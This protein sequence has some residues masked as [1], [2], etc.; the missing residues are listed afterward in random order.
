MALKAVTLPDDL[1]KYLLRA[2]RGEAEIR[3]RDLTRAAN[4]VARSVRSLVFAALAIAGGYG[5][6]QLYL[7]GHVELARTVGV[8]AGALLA[9]LLLTMLLSRPR[10]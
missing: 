10:G 8:S 4:T 9:V 5:A 3:V 1:R 6:L 2:N 7:A